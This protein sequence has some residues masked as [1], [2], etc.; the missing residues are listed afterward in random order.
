M[1]TKLSISRR[2]FIYLLS[3]VAVATGCQSSPAKNANLPWSSIRSFKM[4]GDLKA[5]WNVYGADHPYSYDQA[6]KHGFQR[7][8][9]TS[10][11]TDYHD[12]QKENIDTFLTKNSG[13]PWF[14]PPF[15]ERIV[16]RNIKNDKNVYTPKSS[17][18][19]HDIESVF[20]QDLNKLWSNPAIRKASQVS[21]FEDFEEANYRQ[22]ASWIALPCKWTKELYPNKPVGVYGPQ[23]FNRDYWGL[24]KAST[25]EKRQ[26]LQQK[27]E[28]DLRLWKYI[29]PH[30]DFYITDIYMYYDLP[31]S[32]YYIAASIEENY[33]RCRKLSKKPIY[34]YFWPRF[35]ES[36]KLMMNRELPDYLVEA[37]AVI[38]F[39]TGAKG[40]VVWGAEEKSKGQTYRNLPVFVNSLG[41]VADLSQKIAKA[42]LIIDKSAQELWLTKQPLIRKFKV[43]KSEWILMATNPW[44]SER[45][46]MVVSTN[47]GSRSVQLQIRGKHTEI[48]HL[49]GSS[50]KRISV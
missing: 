3:S 17:I 9:L 44:Q 2:N 33:R 25:P 5:F 15:F 27:H 49:Q 46:T 20:E 8:Q 50:L 36:N 18:Y 10:T 34:A 26:Q 31:D 35:H 6:E 47:C 30:V 28:A 7:V 13:N 42:Q 4:K 23:V 22:Q 40:I 24:A 12:N 29:E 43:S 38:P 21:N 16:K 41:R 48:Y 32:I 19:V 14:K 1:S 39:F 11:F 37:A 45:D